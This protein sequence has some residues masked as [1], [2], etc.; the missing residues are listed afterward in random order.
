M[1]EAQF[2]IAICNTT[3]T[4]IGLAIMRMPQIVALRFDGLHFEFGSS[5]W[6]NHFTD[7][8]SIVGYSVG[9]IRYVIYIFIMIMII[10]VVEAYVLNPKFMASKTELPIFYTFW[11][12]CGRTFQ[13]LADRRCANLYFLLGCFRH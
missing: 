1:L 13:H 6:C 3:L 11:F 12:A 5:C 8:I 7:S 4:M 9:G 2:L 10:H